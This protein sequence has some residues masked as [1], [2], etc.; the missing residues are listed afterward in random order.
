VITLKPDQ[1]TSVD[2][3]ADA[4]RNGHRHVLL[5]GATGSGKSIISTEFVRRS[6]LKDKRVWFS[7][8]RKDLLR[9]MHEVFREFSLDHSY[10]AAGHSHNPFA[11]AHICSTDSLR[12]RLSRVQ[13]PHLAIIDETHRGGEGLDKIIK[14]LKSNGTY[15]IGLSATPWKLSGEG[16][17]CWYDHMVLGPSIKWLIA[18]KR[19]SD[20]KPFA[21]DHIDLSRI[22]V[23]GG[24]YAKGQL[25]EK[26]EQD[27][28]LIGNAV[29]HYKTHAMGKLGV[30]FA[31]SRKH[32]ELLAQA[33]RD[34][35]IPAMH[36]DGETPD[37]E[38]K[39]IS[40]AFANRELL[41][42]CNAELLTF[43]YDLSTASGVKDVCIECVTDCQPTKSL[44]KQMQKWGRGLR[45]DGTQHFIFDHANNIEE[46][47]LP[48]DDREWTLADREKKS[49]ADGEKSIPVKQCEKC[50]FAHRPAPVCPNCGNI[51]EI[52]SRDIEEIEGELKEIDRNAVLVQKK[53]KR[54]EVG[55]ARTID[56]LKRIAEDRGYASG[57]VWKMAKIRGL[58]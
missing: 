44:A 12:S 2:A 56:D 11:Q 49:R 26:M 38:R 15:I 28:V 58:A 40:K 43:G 42:L 39:R 30:T 6:L 4:F 7:V 36:I 21:P 48:C 45:Y 10:I 53:K 32:S 29:R 47:G 16:L 3:V 50:Y 24:D 55:Q 14:W 31:V 17:G 52:Q 41:Q 54:M 5:Q 8:P 51:Y 25:S 46:H 19:L 33:Y 20:Y 1:V 37:G 23:S 57:W 27:R 13:A 35:G 9:Q 34:N 22:K 18:N